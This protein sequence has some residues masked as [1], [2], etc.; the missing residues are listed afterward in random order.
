[1]GLSQNGYLGLPQTLF[2]LIFGLSLAFL[3]SQGD[4]VK[5]AD[6]RVVGEPL[7]LLKL[8]PT[9]LGGQAPDLKAEGLHMLA[10]TSF[11]FPEVGE[12][13]ALFQPR[14]HERI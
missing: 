7:I 4:C 3:L 13:N 14:S 9:G 5:W 1:M 11:T 2:S 10:R 12:E 6:N 8:N